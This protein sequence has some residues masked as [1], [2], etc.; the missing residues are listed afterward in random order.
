M[1][2]VPDLVKKYYKFP[3][4]ADG[5]RRYVFD[6]DNNMCLMF[7]GISDDS[8]D[9]M[10]KAFNGKDIHGTQ[11]H[12]FTLKGGEIYSDKRPDRPCIIIR[13][14]GRLQYIKDDNATPEV[15][16]DTFGQ[17]IVDVLNDK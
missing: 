7:E 17:Y 9:K 15:I 16:Q 4:K 11:N 2:Q 3:L 6:Q 10:I 12:V 8:I 14:W 5:Y 13:G 1:V